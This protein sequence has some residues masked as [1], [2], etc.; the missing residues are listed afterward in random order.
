MY[1]PDLVKA[2]PELT[3]KS[4]LLF[5]AELDDGHEAEHTHAEETLDG[6]L[7][8]TFLNSRPPK[9]SPLCQVV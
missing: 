9:T 1:E 4:V 6:S 8:A 5:H 7:Y 3:L 2:I